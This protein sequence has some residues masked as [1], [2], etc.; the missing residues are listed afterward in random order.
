MVVTIR[1]VLGPKWFQ[2]K[3]F[4]DNSLSTGGLSREEE[5]L[6]DFIGDS[7]IDPYEDPVGEIQK[8]LKRCGLQEIE[9]V[10]SYIQELIQQ[11]LWD[12]E[13]DFDVSI[14]NYKW[15]YK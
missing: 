8:E 11:R 4:D 10:D 7:D 12:I 6:G 13:N 3:L 15:D 5:T 2:Y 9:E 1:D 14:L